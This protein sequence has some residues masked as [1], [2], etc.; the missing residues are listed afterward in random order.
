[1]SRCQLKWSLAAFTLLSG[2]VPTF[3]F[4]S[5]KA[6][7]GTDQLL[8][9]LEEVSP[10]AGTSSDSLWADACKILGKSMTSGTGPWGMG[11]FKSYTCGPRTADAK[12][13]DR[14]DW[15]LSVALAGDKVNLTLHLRGATQTIANVSYVAGKYGLE[16]LDAPEF[17]LM[18]AASLI[19]QMP[20]AMRIDKAHYNREKKAL[21]AK[22]PAKGDKLPAPYQKLTVFSLVFDKK[23][24]IFRPHVVATATRGEKNKPNAV[25]AWKLSNDLPANSVLWAQSSDGRASQAEKLSELI[26]T[27]AARLTERNSSIVGKLGLYKI[28]DAVTDSAGSGYA[29]VRYG[30]SIFNGPVIGEMSIYS[31]ITEL[32]GAPLEGLRFYYDIWPKVERDATEGALLFEGH[33]AVLGWSFGIDSK[34]LVDR[35]DLVPKFSNWTIKA[36]FATMQTDGEIE[37]TPFNAKGVL[38]LGLE[39]GMEKRLIWGTHA[40]AWISSDFGGS[41]ITKKSTTVTDQRAG[42]DIIFKG[43]NLISDVNISFLAFSFYENV[44]I[45]I[46]KNA[47]GTTPDVNALSYKVAYLGGGIAISW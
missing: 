3:L 8:I 18:L 30:H 2:L 38:G 16:L 5:E 43:P 20:F 4:A 17:T 24:G 25:Y 41:A 40:R 35:I 7:L 28:S 32:R 10:A 12:L 29:G 37:T 15:T 22:S 44:S 13:A 26:A 47:D 23:N 39:L 27:N 33:R 11:P 34:W 6:D 36:N 9:Q 14:F 45:A 42:T 1:M 21:V 19:D 31:F 46:D